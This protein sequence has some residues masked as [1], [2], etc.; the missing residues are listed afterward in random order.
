MSIANDRG[1]TKAIANGN[2]A[3]LPL[4]PVVSDPN[5]DKVIDRAKE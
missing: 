5:S 4:Y 3:V 1:E 2:A